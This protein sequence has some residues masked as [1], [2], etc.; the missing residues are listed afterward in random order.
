MTA[1]PSSTRYP[2]TTPAPTPLVVAGHPLL[3]VGP[4]RLYTCG[5]TPYDV[6][7]LG[8]ASTFVWADLVVLAG[9]GRA[10]SRCSAP[11]T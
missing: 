1:T 2:A 4:V 3:P 10:A 5:I 11:A 9:P 6:T 8:H 7:H